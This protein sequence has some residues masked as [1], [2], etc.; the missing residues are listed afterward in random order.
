MA[1]DDVAVGQQCALGDEARDVHVR[2]L[3]TELARVDLAAHRDHNARVEPGHG[4][5]DTGKQVAGLLVEDRAQRDV[6]RWSAGS[7]GQPREHAGR[8]LVVLLGGA[9]GVEHRGLD[10]VGRRRQRVVGVAI[11]GR[12]GHE[13]EVAVEHLQPRVGWQPV[14]GAKQV[15]RVR[16]QVRTEEP[17]SG[18]HDDRGVREPESLSRHGGAEID[19]VADDDLG[20]PPRSD[21]QQPRGSVAGGASSEGVPDDLLF[22][23]AVDGDQRSSCGGV[24]EG[25]AST[26]E[27][28]EPRGPDGAEHRL[29]ATEQHHMAAGR[30]RPGDRQGGEEV[31]AAAGEGEQ[32]SHDPSMHAAGARPPLA[33]ACML[34]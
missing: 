5:Q 11:A 32:D 3:R 31:A 26:G 22:V 20:A 33:P 34:H 4:G 10:V 30:R 17:T 29:L 18:Q 1:D 16:D 19:L 15:E 28:G 7:F 13:G 21:V 12:D 23:S 14:L 27:E 24:G 6:C 8:R 25:G 9:T 2:G